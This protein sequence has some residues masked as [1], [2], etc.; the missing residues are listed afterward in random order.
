MI[1]GGFAKFFKCQIFPMYTDI[2]K[3][4]DFSVY[5]FLYLIVL[6][7]FG[8]KLQLPVTFALCRLSSIS[9]GNCRRYYG[10]RKCLQS[11]DTS[12]TPFGGSR[13]RLRRLVS[14]EK[15]QSQRGC[16]G[17]DKVLQR[18]QQGR[19]SVHACLLNMHKRQA[20][21]DFD[22]RLVAKVF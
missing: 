21:T 20:S 7:T 18:L 5:I 12:T 13:S 2:L 11:I 10:N 17:R 3:Y 16:S 6:N 4:N 15:R 19:R 22:H 9:G 8:I 14:I 1:S